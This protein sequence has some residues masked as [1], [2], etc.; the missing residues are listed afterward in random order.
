MPFSV[1]TGA[2]LILFYAVFLSQIFLI[3]VYYA[4]KL[5]HRIHYV[6]E[7]F[8]PDRYPK[9]YPPMPAEVVQWQAKRR[10]RAFQWVNRLIALLGLSILAGMAINGYRPDLKGGDEIFVM[11]YF[12]LQVSPLIW[13]E[14]RERQQYRLMRKTFDH[15]RR[16]AVLSP[17]RLF[18][19]V[20]PTY[21]VAAVLLYFAWLAYYLAG[22][23]PYA[24]WEG[25]V[26]ITL[27]GITLMNL[28]FAAT[29]AKA[30]RG[31]KLNPYQAY[32]DQLKQIESVAKVLLLASIGI[33]VFLIAT[34]AVDR[35]GLEVFDPPLASLYLQLCVVFGIGLTFR[36]LEIEAIDFEVYRDES[37]P[38]S[39]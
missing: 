16:K 2:V 27:G 28:F 29:I 1:S 38:F 7:N 6:L 13:A 15:S 32:E 12:F 30:L 37:A 19:F 8:P 25:E 9:L 4:G 35:H 14:I 3:S 11:L 17:R 39:I 23:G 18:D 34:I 22:Q 10:L 26:F 20:S 31:R 24:G 5:S 21:L 33:S 36:M